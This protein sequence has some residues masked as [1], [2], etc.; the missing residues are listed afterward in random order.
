[1]TNL[2]NE[3]LTKIIAND[4]RVEELAA[5]LEQI[6]QKEQAIN[7]AL[8][9]VDAYRN[10]KIHEIASIC[11][12]LEQAGIVSENFFHNIADNEYFY[13]CELEEEE[14]TPLLQRVYIGRSSTFYYTAAEGFEFLEEIK[15]NRYGYELLDLMQ[16]LEYNL[17]FEEVALLKA[18]LKKECDDDELEAIHDYIIKE[19][20]ISEI[21][22]ELFVDLGQELSFLESDVESIQQFAKELKFM[23]RYLKN[24]KSTENAITI[25]E[26]YLTMCHENDALNLVDVD[27]STIHN[28]EIREILEEMQ[29]D[30]KYEEQKLTREEERRLFEDAGTVHVFNSVVEDY[31]FGELPEDH[32]TGYKYFYSYP[33]NR[34]VYT[35]EKVFV[36]TNNGREYMDALTAALEDF[37]DEGLGI[38]EFTTFF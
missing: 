12:D 38:D 35:D 37:D 10:L 5:R 9:N 29:H 8:E 15:A 21:D 30:V 11:Y 28:Y 33:K 2:T 19:N 26:S 32:E 36:F 27:L 17:T 25:V 20:G 14:E 3:Q 6:E 31:E 7:E 13:F 22:D 24:Y 4:P 23:D 16:T 34:T 18:A 1:M